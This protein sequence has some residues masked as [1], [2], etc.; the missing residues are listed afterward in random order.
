MSV[1]EAKT[2]HVTVAGDLGEEID[3]VAPEL[4]QISEERERAREVRGFSWANRLNRSLG[5]VCRPCP[6]GR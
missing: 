3:R 5:H 2:D 6:V 4:E 1:R